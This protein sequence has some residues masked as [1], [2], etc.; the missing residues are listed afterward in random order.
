[1]NRPILVTGFEPFDGLPTN[2]SQQVLE[3]LKALDEPDLRLALLPV[4]YQQAPI[5][6][7]GLLRETYRAVL[8]LGVAADRAEFCLER[9]AL[10]RC[11]QERLDNTGRRPRTARLREDARSEYRS[12]FDLDRQLERLLRDGH[13][14][15]ISDTAGAFLCNAVFFWARHQ[16]DD[17]TPCGFL[18]LPPTPGLHSEV[19]GVSLAEQVRAVLAILQEIRAATAAQH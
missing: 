5:R 16:L 11:D 17:H 9:V 14:A 18:H 3:A 8:L 10:N 1:M 7:D 15:R 12:T 2:P 6:L 19:A 13:P 4:C